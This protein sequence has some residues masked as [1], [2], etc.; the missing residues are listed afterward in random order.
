MWNWLWSK[1]RT[2]NVRHVCWLI[3]VLGMA[4]PCRG[5]WIFDGR[6]ST[7][8]G[9]PDEL[10]VV[11][12]TYPVLRLDMGGQW[13]DFE[14]KASTNNFTDLCYYVMS[15]GTNVWTTDT[16]VWVYFTDDYAADV[17]QWQK[18][19]PFTAIVSQLTDVTN[20]QVEAVIVCPSHE[21][22]GD[23]ADW[24]SPTNTRLV[25]SFVRYDGIGFEM[26]VTGTK[27]HWGPVVPV[28]WR[29]GR[30]AP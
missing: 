7:W 25:W 28:E 19:A 13:T 1:E 12:E 24:M 29:R 18:A 15:S 16:N 10:N 17:R 8:E 11:E 3:V 6:P 26:N 4:R 23:W 20:S 27:Q 22:T 30:I 2:V 5:E 9:T 21:C 14:L